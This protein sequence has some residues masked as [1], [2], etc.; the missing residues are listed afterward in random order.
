MVS[1]N[2]K[3]PLAFYARADRHS[4]DLYNLFVAPLKELLQYKELVRNI[5]SRDLKV[6]YRRSVLGILWTILAPL[7]SMTVMWAVFQYALQVKIPNYPVYILSGIITWNLFVQSST[8][9]AASIL[10]NSALLS[11]LRLPRVIFPLS[12]VVNNLVNFGFAVVAFVLVVLITRA[13]LHGEM[14]LL[15]LVLIPLL[16]FAAGWSMLVSS[17]CVFFRDLQY[18]LDIGLQAVFY[19]TPILYDPKSLPAKAS[20]IVQ[21]NPIAK[22]IHLVRNALYSGEWPDPQTYMVA[23]AMGVFM[24]LV[25][26][27]AFQRLQRKFIYWL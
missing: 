3:E 15:P 11:K 19:L 21:V 9:G 6:R 7:L 16:L 1:E 27:V 5:V 13:P 17:L 2:S 20:W 25:G 12:A 23:L 22:F 14:R 10:N 4:W 18:M 26:W 8:A 24:F